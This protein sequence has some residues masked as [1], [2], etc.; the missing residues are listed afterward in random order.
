MDAHCEHSCGTQYPALPVKY[1]TEIAHAKFIDKILQNTNHPLQPYV[2]AEVEN[3]YHGA[4]HK[5][6]LVAK[7][8]LTYKKLTSKA[9]APSNEAP[10]PPAEPWSKVPIVVNTELPAKHSVSDVQI[11][12]V[13]VNSIQP[14][15][16][17]VFYT[18]GSVQ[19]RKA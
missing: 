9:P 8:A 2:E 11:K 18:D 6:S 1:R 13:A 14:N 12:A 17:P 3:P 7:S 19:N 10:S 16:R 15:G 4:K 5:N